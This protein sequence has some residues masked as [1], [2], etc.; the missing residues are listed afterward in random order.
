MCECV[1]VTEVF[2]VFVESFSSAVKKS[3]PEYHRN[4]NGILSRNKNGKYFRGKFYFP[5]TGPGLNHSLYK[6][7]KQ[8]WKLFIVDLALVF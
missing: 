4:G 7:T 6:H 3:V 5:F 8:K 1:Y 2:I